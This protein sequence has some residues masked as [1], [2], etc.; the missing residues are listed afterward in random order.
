[1]FDILKYIKLPGIVFDM[2]LNVQFAVTPQ[3]AFVLLVTI[4]VFVF[5]EQSTLDKLMI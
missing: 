2:F 1:M 4:L 3:C 5:R